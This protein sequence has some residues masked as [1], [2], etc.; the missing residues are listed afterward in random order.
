MVLTSAEQDA[1]PRYRPGIGGGQVESHFIK[2]NLPEARA[3]WLKFTLL[4][5]TGVG[6]PAVAEAWAIAFNLAKDG[7][8]VALKSTWPLQAASLGA[9]RF[10]LRVGEI[11]WEAGSCK[12]ELWD[13]QHRVSWALT[14][15]TPPETFR[16]LPAEWMYT[17]PLPKTKTLSPWID[18]RFS[19]TVTVDGVTTRVEAAPGML[20]HNWGRQQAEF[21]TWA[22]TNA[23][24]GLDGALFEGVTSKL[25]FGPVTSPLLTVLHVRIPGERLN[26]NGLGQLLLT[27]SRPRGLSWTVEGRTRDRRVWARFQAPRERFVGVN[28][29]DPDDR[30]AHCLNTKIADGELVVRGKTARGWSLIMSGVASATC[31]LEIGTRGDTFGVPIQIP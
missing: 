17:G 20:G 3:V 8:H 29:H 7:G 4:E 15:D 28:Y 25:K 11:A 22:H 14:F 27:R 9:Q 24:D 2:F 18:T 21:W 1:L 12:G 31:A 30:I 5:K 26:L 23:F 16:M 13:E 10:S 19:G 6:A